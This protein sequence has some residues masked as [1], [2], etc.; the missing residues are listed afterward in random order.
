MDIC[1]TS[2]LLLNISRCEVRT[3]FV[4][5]TSLEIFSFLKTEAMK[6]GITENVCGKFNYLLVGFVCPGGDDVG[7]I[8]E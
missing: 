6:R 7:S 4:F 1:G 2:N 3:S 5:K 8:I